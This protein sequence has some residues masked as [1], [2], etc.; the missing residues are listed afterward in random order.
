[1]PRQVRA[2]AVESAPLKAMAPDR[3]LLV[4]YGLTVEFA[5]GTNGDVGGFTVSAGRA[6]GIEFTRSGR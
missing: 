1:L 5:R 6:A 4:G 3:F 2:K